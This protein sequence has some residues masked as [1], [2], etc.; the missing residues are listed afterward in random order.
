MADEKLKPQPHVRILNENDER[1]KTIQRIAE[2]LNFQITKIEEQQIKGKTVLNIHFTYTPGPTSS[3]EI[4]VFEDYLKEKGFSVRLFPTQAVDLQTKG[5]QPTT[6]QETTS[7]AG[8]E[9][10]QKR[11]SPKFSLLPTTRLFSIR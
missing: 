5:P 4:N 9:A 6:S 11:P 7:P 2:R 10:F 3:I 8:V 1:Y